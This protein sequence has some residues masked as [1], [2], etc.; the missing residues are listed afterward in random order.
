MFEGVL[1]KK[2]EET[3]GAT[4]G[5]VTTT[6]TSSDP[7]LFCTTTRDMP[8][9]YKR[10]RDDDGESEDEQKP[11]RQI[12]PVA[13]LPEDFAGEPLDGAQYLFTVR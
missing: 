2:L 1:D 6:S 11:G 7:T 8:P 13:N 10:K 5:T 12:L 9:G 3:I 4:I